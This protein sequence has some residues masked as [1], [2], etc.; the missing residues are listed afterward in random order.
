M[1]ADRRTT[2][3]VVAVVV[4]YAVV[5]SFDRFL[6]VAGSDVPLVPGVVLALG[7]LLGPVAA[8][9]VGVG[10]VL[11]EIVSGTLAV[12]TVVGF[13]ST[14]GLAVVAAR[15]WGSFGLAATAESP[16]AVSASSGVEYALVAVTTATVVA[17]ATALGSLVVGATTFQAAI[18]A[19]LPS[20]LRSVIVVGPV[21]LFLGY[22]TVERR[23]YAVILFSGGVAGATDGRRLGW[24]LLAAGV[25]WC[26]SGYAVGTVFDAADLEYPHILV[27][28]L[29]RWVLPVL[30]LAGP[31]GIY[32]Q[33]LVGIAF[34][35]ACLWGVERL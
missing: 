8:W 3:T 31:G 29:G 16:G 13:L 22:A 7:L 24:W 10:Y 28:R 25:G 23:G 18:A 9:G 32:L 19:T 2:A 26:A 33:V 27:N 11:V 34:V 6:A 14:L 5:A 30:D 12:D 35:G 1:P 15:L 20:A 4:V 21:V 17:A